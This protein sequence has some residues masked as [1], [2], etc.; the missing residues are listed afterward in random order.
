[1]QLDCSGSE[2]SDVRFHPRQGMALAP[3]DIARQYLS[4]FRSLLQRTGSVM[5]RL[6]YIRYVPH[7]AE[8]ESGAVNWKPDSVVRPIED[9]PQIFWRDG[10]PWREAN[11]WALELGRNRQ[12]KLKS[13]DLHLKLTRDLH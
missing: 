7:M 3:Q 10:T 13:V 12:V 11:L 5:A 6:E 8:V 2:V 1:M 4:K 9:L